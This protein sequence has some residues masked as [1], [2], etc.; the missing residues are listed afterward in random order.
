[1]PNVPKWALKLAMG[2]GA[3]MVTEGVKI[4]N[5][6][7]KDSGFQFEFDSVEKALKD[8]ATLTS[9]RGGTTKQSN[10]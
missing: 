3:A 6:K 10:I 1:M 8:L 4:S 9:L 7:I 2:E 5:Q